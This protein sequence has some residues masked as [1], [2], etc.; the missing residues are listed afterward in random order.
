MPVELLK[1]GMVVGFVLGGMCLIGK[2]WIGVPLLASGIGF[3]IAFERAARRE[4]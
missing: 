3:G 2:P 4:G 1:L